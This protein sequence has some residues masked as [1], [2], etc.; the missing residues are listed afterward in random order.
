MPI[1][2]NKIVQM[3]FKNEQFERG[4]KESLDSL[5]KLKKALNLD[6]SAESLSNLEKIASSFDISGIAKGVDNIAD[7]FT[8]LGNIGQEIFHR[9]SRTAV[10]T[11]QNVVHTITSMPNAGMSKYEQKNKSVQM[12]RSAMPNKSIEEIEQVLAKLN[13]YTDLTS[14]DFSTMANSIGKFV[15]AGVDL[16]VAEKVMEGIANETASAGGEISA[17]NI[18][19]YN[20]SQALAAGAVKLM[21]WRSIQN[22][23][24][25]TKEFKEQIIQTAIA[26]GKLSKESEKVGYYY[27][28]SGKKN[29]KSFSRL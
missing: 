15:S 16:D 5:E 3:T 25:D 14:Y 28:G 26:M 29:T 11:M 13:E 4:V 1:A 22:Q 9:I 21:D 17:A 2:D 6:K 23:N 12:I 24:L 7:R 8:L 19:M 10:D 20:F 27:K 18:A